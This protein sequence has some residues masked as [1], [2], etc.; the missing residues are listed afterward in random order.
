MVSPVSPNVVEARRG[1]F[2][3][4]CSGCGGAT[5]FFDQKLAYPWLVTGPAPIE[6]MPEDVRRDYAEAQ[7]VAQLSPRSAAALL[8]LAVQKLCKHLGENGENINHDIA[9]LVKKGLPS[10]IQKALDIVRVVGNNA[11]HPGELDLKDTSEICVPLF[12]LINSVVDRMIVKPQ[13][14]DEHFSSLP[15]SSRAAIDRRDNP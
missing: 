11:G 14:L 5:I 2:K 9:E 1:V 7:K 4:T 3:L 15:E 12:E 13:Q 6:G 10:G 8:R